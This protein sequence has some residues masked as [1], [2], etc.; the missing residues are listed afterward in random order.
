M[1]GKNAGGEQKYDSG[2]ITLTAAD[3][4]KATLPIAVGQRNLSFEVSEVVPDGY[5]QIGSDSALSSD[6]KTL[7]FTLTN[8]KL[9]SLSA[10]K[11]WDD[12]DNAKGMRPGSVRLQLLKDG[13][14]FG[15]PVTVNEADA[16]T[17]TCT[18]SRTTARTTRPSPCTRWT[19]P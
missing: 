8:Q 13:E 5:R 17:Y 9:T 15:D 2:T 16:W 19:P 1:T 14:P 10:E 12:D 6:G 3:S 18:T 7:T 4:W 11:V